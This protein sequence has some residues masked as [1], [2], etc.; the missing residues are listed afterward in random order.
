MNKSNK[1][2]HNDTEKRAEVTREEGRV[3][4]NG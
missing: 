4:E 1:N 2:K 3:R